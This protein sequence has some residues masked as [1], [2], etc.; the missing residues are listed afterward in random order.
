MPSDYESISNQGAEEKL[1][2]AVSLLVRLYAERTHFI[3]E[4]LQNAED[5]GATRVRFDLRADCLE[6]WHDGRPFDDDDVRGVCDVGKGTKK[7]DLTQIG[8]FGIGFKSVYAFTLRPEIHCGGEHFAIE[9]YT[10]PHG[11]DPITVPSPWT[12]LFILPFNRGDIVPDVAHGEIEQGL[13]KLNPGAMLFLRH[14]VEIEWSAAGVLGRRYTRHEIS[15]GAA[16]RI[17]VTSDISGIGIPTGTWLIFDA[18]VLAEDSSD[19]LR[20]EVAFNLVSA[21]STDKIS[22]ADAATLSV[23]FPTA[24]R[25]GLGFTIQGPYRTTP[26]RDNVPAFDLWN[27]KLVNETATLVVAALGHLREMKLLTVDAL[28]TLPLRTS[29]FPEDGMFRPIFE[30]V[31]EALATQDLIPTDSGEFVCGAQAQIARGPGITEIFSNGAP[32]A[33]ERSAK[34]LGWVSRVITETHMVE[35]YTYFRKV[36]QIEEI[37]PETIVRQLDGRFLEKQPDDWL[38]QFYGFLEARDSLWRKTPWPEGPARSVPI[39]RLENG[40]H[41]LPF[42][43]DGS[44]AVYL[45]APSGVGDIP[46]VRREVID[47]KPSS[48]FLEKLGLCPFDTIAMLREIVLP[49]Y[50]INPPDVSR[51]QNL[52]DLRCIGRVLSETKNDEKLR[53]ILNDVKNTP[54]VYASNASPP[55][56]ARYVK[57]GQVYFASDELDM[58]LGG[59]P[60]GW[61]LDNGY[62]EDLVETFLQLGVS[63]TIRVL[64]SAGKPDYQGY[65]SLGDHRRGVKGFDPEVDIDGL[66]Y[67]VEHPNVER[68]RYVWNRIAVPNANQVQGVVETSSRVDFMHKTPCP[69]YSAMGNALANSAWL[70]SGSSFVKPTALTMEDL[71]DDFERDETLCRQLDMK[72]DEVAKL[73]QKHDIPAETFTIAK[74]IAGDPELYRRFLTLSDAKSAK[75]EFPTRPTPDQDRRAKHV[76]QD[77]ETAPPKEYDQRL[78]SVRTSEPVQD[79]TTWLRELYMNPSEQMICQICEQEMPF[80]KRDGEYYFEAVEALDTLP[81]EQHQNH[82]ALCPLCA[83]KYKE[84]V[85]RDEDALQRCQTLIIAADGDVVAIQLGGEDATLRF[86]ASHLLDLKTLLGGEVE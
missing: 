3:L 60:K 55:R 24:T 69:K 58:Y 22:V 21:K 62:P 67:A 54:L 44:P 41:V 78:R 42:R 36:L 74:Q 85:K 71:P 14:I 17:S 82:L 7:D 29:D 47:D 72:V 1:E 5:A 27:Q 38:K 52:D 39:I 80:K 37:T 83:A 86:V 61:F 2:R 25:T 6:V 16:R 31:K 51:E 48:Q 23:F 34:R 68:S 50:H 13:S 33:V 70:P 12:T 9:K 79:P 19:A 26:A 65:V 45:T 35:L 8:K 75:P 10:H 56:Q 53:A 46:V 59:N 76:R 81:K 63:R 15:Q 30:A 77:A 28:L 11:V 4:L 64:H 66:R 32:A 18:P 84:F 73:L 40:T 43:K 49:K 57:P 20:V